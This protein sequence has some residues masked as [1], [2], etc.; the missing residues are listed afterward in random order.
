MKN[1]L[2]I[3]VAAL[4]AINLVSCGGQNKKKIGARGGAGTFEDVIVFDYKRN[5][6]K[7]KLT[8]ADIADVEYIPI[9]KSDD[10]LMSGDSNSH[11]MSTY[12]GK[13]FVL[14]ADDNRLMMFD[15]AGKPI[16]TI[17]TIGRG[18]NE[19]TNL[20]HLVGVDEALGEVYINDGTERIQVYGLDGAWRRT[21]NAQINGFISGLQLLNDEEIL[22][23][24][25]QRDGVYTI[26]RQDGSML[27]HMP[28]TLPLEFQ[29]DRHGR[30]SYPNILPE[31]DGLNLFD[32]RTDTI[33]N[34]SAG[35]GLRPVIVDVT[36]YPSPEE[37]YGPDN[38]QFMPMIENDKYIIGGVICSHWITPDV[39]A[40]QYLYDKKQKKWF[41]L[42]KG[43][44]KWFVNDLVS[45]YIHI[46]RS[47]LTLNAGYAAVFISPVNMMGEN[48]G[49]WRSEEFAK[50][51]E[52]VAEDDNPI[53]MLV[54][55]K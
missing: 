8:L 7:S 10:F 47:A 12:I 18:P 45:G 32:L 48:R 4:V 5:Y 50:V 42:D 38:A 15:R 20:H 51:L 49:K 46:P 41:E 2:L 17:G 1:K 52:G 16:R 31:E 6:P 33:W 39:K 11:G 27:R 22:C 35:G 19:Y 23:F 54:K 36:R 44:D 40:R 43:E 55:F 3:L 14:T 21:I 53:M 9:G 25:N 30:M 13:T 24:D 28:I 37:L 34:F 29:L 26:S